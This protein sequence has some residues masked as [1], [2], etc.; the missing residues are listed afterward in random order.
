MDK[1]PTF[2]WISETEPLLNPE[3]GLYNVWKYF[4]EKQLN[5]NN[6]FDKLK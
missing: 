4:G 5:D 3:V 1:W 6:G 2:Y